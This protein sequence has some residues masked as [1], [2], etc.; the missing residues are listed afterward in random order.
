MHEQI[1]QWQGYRDVE[2]S[3]V[4]T[5]LPDLS[6]RDFVLGVYLGWCGI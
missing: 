3:K 1:Q 5:T 2:K 6:N 4:Q